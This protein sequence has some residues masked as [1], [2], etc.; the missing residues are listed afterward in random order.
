MESTMTD[1]QTPDR[2]DAPDAS[3]PEVEAHGLPVLDAQGLPQHAGAD[4][5]IFCTSIHSIILPQ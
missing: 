1:P 3:G 2:D 4:A 5:E